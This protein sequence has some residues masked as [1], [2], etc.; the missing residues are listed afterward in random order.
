MGFEL[1]IDGAAK[2]FIAQSGIQTPLLASSN[3]GVHSVDLNHEIKSKSLR[4][5]M[6]LLKGPNFFPVSHRSLRQGAQELTWPCLA[7]HNGG[8]RNRQNDD[9]F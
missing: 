1:W 3:P 5:E 6:E 9:H 2:I 7:V 8:N 4:M